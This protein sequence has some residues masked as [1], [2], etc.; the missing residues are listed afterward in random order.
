MTVKMILATTE[1]GGIGWQGKLPFHCQEDLA[2]FK[3]QTKYCHLIYGRTTWEGLPFYPNGFPERDNTIVSNSH[4][5]GVLS[6]KEYYTQ[7]TDLEGVVPYL[8]YHNK[9]EDDIWIT[10]GKSIYE[11]LLPYVK[12]IHHT[13]I[14][15]EYE[16]D[17]FM[18]MSFLEEG[19]ECVEE[20]VL[21]E[22]ATVKVWRRTM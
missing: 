20:R 15:G 7:I 1:Q 13:E 9:H 3:E 4:E 19:W 10:G 22:I 16:C 11:Q 2:Y 5:E 12:E 17:T 18:D 6:D 21:S 14:K 8:R